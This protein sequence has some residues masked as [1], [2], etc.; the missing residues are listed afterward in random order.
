[1]TDI[2]KLIAQEMDK[3][4]A[5]L[6]SYPW[7]D[8]RAYGMWLA[9]TYHMVTHT[10]RLL[11][12]AG[13]SFPIEQTRLHNR[14]VDHSKE[15]RGH[16]KVCIQDIKALGYELS[17]FPKLYQSEVM[18]QIQYYWIQHRNPVSFFGYTL[19]LECLAERFGAPVGKML[20][21]KHGME[22]TKF[23]RLH[24]EDDIEHTQESY[25]L[26]ET[27]SEH[28][29]ALIAENLVLSSSIYRSMV[30]EAKVRCD[31]IGLKRSA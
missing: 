26:I 15:E 30:V 1:M 7:Q 29:K 9:Q 11:A 4:G 19:A 20:I 10:T 18:Y 5:V 3:A 21:E 25:K 16:E 28:E 31:D 27:M 12:L 2:S 14:F 24:S 22:A 23:V 13:A 17:D 6:H 8:P